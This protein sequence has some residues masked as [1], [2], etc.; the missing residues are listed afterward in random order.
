[1]LWRT[2]SVNDYHVKYGESEILS[3]VAAALRNLR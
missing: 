1:M 3:F 2:T